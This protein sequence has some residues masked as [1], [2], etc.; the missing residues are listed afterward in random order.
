MLNLKLITTSQAK[1]LYVAKQL[2]SVQAARLSK[3]EETTAL[4]VETSSSSSSD[5][6]KESLIQEGLN[7]I[8]STWKKLRR[9]DQKGGSSRQPKTKMS[10][11]LASLLVYTVGVK[12]HGLDS[13]VEYAPEH[14]FSLSETAANRIVKANMH[15]LI[16]HTQ[17]HL[18]RVYPKGTRVDSSN[19]QPHRYWAAGCQVVAINWQTFGRSFSVTLGCRLTFSSDLGNMINQAMFQR[20]GRAGYVLKPDALRRPDK[21][22]LVHKRTQHIFDVTVSHIL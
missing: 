12:C 9:K 11:K 4:E 8:R 2:A 17:T 22:D 1:N 20:N 5:G 7:D 16:K 13:S 18:V 3:V 6:E 19:Y 15:D 10:F 14:I 21:L